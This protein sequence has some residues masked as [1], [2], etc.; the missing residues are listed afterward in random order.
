MLV[1]VSGH[2][3][4]V[5]FLFFSFDYLGPGTLAEVTRLQLQVPSHILVFDGL[6]L[7]S[8]VAQ[9]GPQLVILPFQLLK[10]GMAGMAGLSPATKISVNEG[11]SSAS[12]IKCELVGVR[13]QT[14]PAAASPWHDLR[15]S[16]LLSGRLVPQQAN[17]IAV[18]QVKGK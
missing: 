7:N 16:H 6:A 11:M 5:L 4:R 2:P 17:K 9:A 15:I 12:S 3:V 13:N 14:V 8:S 18:Q 1:A 10:S